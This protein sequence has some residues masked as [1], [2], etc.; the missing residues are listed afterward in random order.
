MPGIPVF[1]SSTLSPRVPYTHDPAL[2]LAQTNLFVFV[3]HA[4]AIGQIAVRNEESVVIIVVHFFLAVFV[5]RTPFLTVIVRVA[6]FG[7]FWLIFPFFVRIGLVVKQL[8]QH[9]LIN[10][11]ISR[12]NLFA[13]K[14]ATT[15]NEGTFLAPCAVIRRTVVVVKL[16][17]FGFHALTE[18]A[19]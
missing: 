14:R 17:Q 3:G 7:V 5:Q 8:Q 4:F 13:S 6:V 11:C 16:Q 2:S 15:G 18:T 19:H 12:L 9:K 1:C 10:K